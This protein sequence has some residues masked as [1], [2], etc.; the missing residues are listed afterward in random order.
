MEIHSR[1]T[2]CGGAFYTFYVRVIYRWYGHHRKECRDGMIKVVDESDASS[3]LKIQPNMGK[4][5]QTGYKQFQDGA[6]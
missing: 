6:K 4:Q 2:I 5:Q 3:A 1:V